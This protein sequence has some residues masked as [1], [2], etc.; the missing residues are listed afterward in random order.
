MIYPFAV[1]SVCVCWPDDAGPDLQSKPFA[2]IL[3]LCARDCA[4]GVVDQY[5]ASEVSAK[6]P[7]TRHGCP[8]IPCY[9]NRSIHT[10]LDFAYVHIVG[11]TSTIN[12]AIGTKVP[13]SLPCQ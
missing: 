5:T 9:L 11:H 12:E 6:T 2:Y 1:R 4:R 10:E 3:C 7:P 8:D 13:Y